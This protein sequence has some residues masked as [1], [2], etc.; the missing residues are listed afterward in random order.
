MLQAPEN[1]SSNPGAKGQVT[2]LWRAAQI[3]EECGAC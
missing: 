2:N 1:G 3:D